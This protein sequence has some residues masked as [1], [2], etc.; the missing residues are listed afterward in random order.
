LEPPLGEGLMDALESFDCVRSYSGGEP[1]AG[2]L[3]VREF[4]AHAAVRAADAG[5]STTYVASDPEL[6]GGVVL[7]YIT[8]TLSHVRLTA[9]EKRAGGMR[10]AW[11]ADFGA[12]RIGMI[13]TDRRYAGQGF[14]HRLLQTAIDSAVVMSEQVTVRFIIAD[15][16]DTQLAWYE[17]QGFVVNRSRAE[18]ER[19]ARVRESTGVAATSMRLDLGADPRL[20]GA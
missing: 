9:G 7:G 20:L 6:A 2:E 16:V 18:L 5:A 8:L 19:L 15:A 17:R 1:D 4:L 14:G 12:L 10:D 13:G 11:G 3:M